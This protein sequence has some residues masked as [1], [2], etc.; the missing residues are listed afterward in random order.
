[1]RIARLLIA[2]GLCIGIAVFA[3]FT[4]EELK[5]GA[6]TYAPPTSFGAADT[7][8]AA[9]PTHST[10]SNPL[11]GLSTTDP[12]KYIPILRDNPHPGK[13]APF[14]RTA[15]L[16]QPPYYQTAG[17]EVWELCAY[18]VTDASLT[19]LFAHY[20]QQAKQRGM[21]LNKQ[22]PTSENRPGG[23][24][25]SWTKGQD[26]LEV[27]AWPLPTESATPPLSPKTP[28]QWV[29]KYSYPSQP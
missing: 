1:M 3:V 7:S 23:I 16:G 10:G 21:K 14:M 2:L 28:L 12:N 18:R 13:V 4:I 27:T 26:R 24:V 5:A 29:V 22:R 17:N 25:L 6:T 20:D 19:A 8:P 11:A 15:P 9:V